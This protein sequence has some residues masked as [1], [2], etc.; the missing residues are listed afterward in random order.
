LYNFFPQSD[1]YCGTEGICFYNFIFTKNNYVG[2]G[3]TDQFS[4]THNHNFVHVYFLI[5][6]HLYSEI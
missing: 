6:M 2:L 5:N 1:L 3:I 4:S